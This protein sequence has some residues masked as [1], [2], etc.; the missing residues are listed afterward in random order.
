MQWLMVTARKYN[1]CFSVS[2][3][4]SGHWC[5]CLN[6]VHLFLFPNSPSSSRVFPFSTL[7][8]PSPSSLRLYLWTEDS[9]V[10]RNPPPSK[11][12]PK[13]SNWR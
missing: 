8:P 6:F 3:C 1:I 13:A 4:A 11:L 2:E 7:P 12:T 5:T 9:K 10:W